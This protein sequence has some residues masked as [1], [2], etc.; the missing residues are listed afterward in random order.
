MSKKKKYELIYNDEGK[1]VCPQCNKQDK[2]NITDYNL[3]EKDEEK[4]M[5]YKYK[6]SRCKIEI[7]NWFTFKELFEI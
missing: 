3:I 1:L 6:C 7:E 5:K 2:V 4:Y